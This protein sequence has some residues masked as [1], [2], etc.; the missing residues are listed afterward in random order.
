MCVCVCV[1]VCVYVCVCVCVCVCVFDRVDAVCLRALPQHLPFCTSKA[2][3]LSTFVLGK[4][5]NSIRGVSALSLST[6][7]VV[8]TPRDQTL[9]LT[10]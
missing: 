6:C 7:S 4:Q 1:C 5:V 2:R 10:F 9:T 3:K 8:C